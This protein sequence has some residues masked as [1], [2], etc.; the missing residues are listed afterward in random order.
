M[1]EKRVQCCFMPSAS[2]LLYL[3]TCRDE[4]DNKGEFYIVMLCQATIKQKQFIC[5]F[6]IYII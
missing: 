3:E 6:Q 2:L 4:T 5:F 1:S